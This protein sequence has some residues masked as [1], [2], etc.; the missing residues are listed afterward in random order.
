MSGEMLQKARP[1]GHRPALQRTCPCVTLLRNATVVNGFDGMAV[2]NR[3][4]KRLTEHPNEPS[5]TAPGDQVPDRRRGGSSVSV[6]GGNDGGG[7]Q[8]LWYR[9]G[10]RASRQARQRVE[11][12]LSR[13]AG[14]RAFRPA[15]ALRRIRRGDRGRR[16]EWTLLRLSPA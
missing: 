11:H 7:R 15:Q 8:R 2:T 9:A 14:R 6:S 16:P 4:Y 1:A 12:Y 3:R 5:N 13:G 10:G